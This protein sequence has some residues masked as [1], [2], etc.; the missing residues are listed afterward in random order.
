MRTALALALLA[1]ALP[2]H[3]EPVVVASGA[4][5]EGL[6][7]H[8]GRIYFTEMGADRVTIIENGGTREFWRLP[9]CGPTQIVRFGP[10]GFVVSVAAP[11]GSYNPA[12]R[13]F[14]LVMKSDKRTPSI[15]TIADDGR[16]REVEIRQP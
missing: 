13:K 6:M 8:D 3:A 16:A 12:P 2:T 9:G 1:L 4:Y 5:P 14:N 7:W 10:K 15:V 11:Q